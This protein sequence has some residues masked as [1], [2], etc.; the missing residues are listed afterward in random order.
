MGDKD[1]EN[2]MQELQQLLLGMLI[3][4]S[5]PQE[6]L[7]YLLGLFQMCPFAGNKNNEQSEKVTIDMF[8]QQL[9]TL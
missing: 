9:Y 4:T 6:F 5:T 8:N 7:Y 3:S 2:S 1:L